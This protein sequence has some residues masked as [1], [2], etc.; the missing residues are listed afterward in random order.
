MYL[1]NRDLNSPQPGSIDQGLVPA[2][3][4]FGHK[5][6]RDDQSS[7]ARDAVDDEARREARLTIAKAFGTR[8]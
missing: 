1:T 7:F 3:Q 5:W 6:K 2:C 4:T 8:S